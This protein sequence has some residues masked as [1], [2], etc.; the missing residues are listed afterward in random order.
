MIQHLP[1]KGFRMVRYYGIY[2]RPVRDKIHKMVASVLK[3]LVK[4][5]EKVAGYFAR[6]RGISP[7]E[8]RRELEERFGDRKTRCE[9]CGSTR[10]ILIRIWSKNAGV[11]YEIGKNDPQAVEGRGQV[12]GKK[13]DVPRICEQL[14][15]AF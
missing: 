5:A 3:D 11:I 12:A 13:T 8:Y 15:F 9:K 4:T 10:M 2:A 7:E 6:K 1:P 14:V